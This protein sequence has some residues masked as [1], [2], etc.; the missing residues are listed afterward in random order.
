MTAAAY[1]PVRIPPGRPRASRS[2]VSPGLPA[3]GGL[4]GTALQLQQADLW[5]AGA[6]AA[7]A[8]VAL[9]AGAWAWRRRRVLPLVLAV[10]ALGFGLAGWRAADFA[11]RALPPALEGRDLLVEGRVASLPQPREFGLGLAFDI[12]AV[13][14]GAPAGAVPRRVQ[15]T[16]SRSPGAAEDSPGTSVVP[17]AGERWRILVRL[18]APHGPLN[19]RGFDAEL[20]WWERGIQALGSVRQGR[21]DPPPER[22][23]AA[24]PLSVERARQAVRDAILARASPADPGAWGVVAALVVGDGQ[25][26]TPADWDLYRL[27]GIAHLVSISGLHV[28]AFAWLASALAGALWRRSARLCEACPAPTAALWAGLALAGGYA[29]FSG[30]GVPAQRTVWMLAAAGWLRTCGYRWPWPVTGSVVACGVAAADPWALLQPGFWLSFVAVAVL[31]LGEAGTAPAAPAEEAA[32]PRPSAWGWR[33][34]ALGLL[35]EQ[36]RITLALAPLTLLLFGQWSLVG[37]LANLVAIPWMTGVVLPLA[38]AGVVCPPLWAGAAA[39]VGGL[40]PLLQALAA[41]PGGVWSVAAPPGW[42]AAGALAGGA[43]AVLPLPLAL[44]VPG[45]LLLLPVLLWQPPR[46]APGA[47]EVLAADIGQGTAVLVRTA[48]H[49]LLYD[50]GPRWAPDQ[51]AGQRVLV[52]LLRAL[53]VRLDRLVVSHQDTDHSGG[54]AAV[55][56]AHPRAD[57][58]ASLP[59]GHPLAALRAPQACLSGQRWRWDGVDFE[60]LHPSE[61][62]WAGDERP[63][64]TRPNALSCVLRVS[65]ADGARALLTGDIERPQE[66]ALVAAHGAAGL[67]ADLL[68]VPHHGSKT[69]SSPA[70]LDAV[71]P[72]LALVQAGY[73]NRYGHPAPRVRERHAQRGIPL[74]ETAACGAARWSSDTPGRLACERHLRRRAWHHRPERGLDIAILTGDTG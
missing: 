2:P 45:L 43:W 3:L 37:W 67:R 61:A 33:R 68:L 29:V 20:G 4:A 62:D 47:F 18:R 13:P 34:H 59:A 32:D 49:D 58:L 52:P 17:R 66:A 23:S 53:G 15:L 51:D 22:L 63:T 70:F 26:I 50:A 39:A 21:G 56:A 7:L 40:A 12:D 64:A 73:R 72:R 28:T 41:V 36:T 1:V 44:R 10:A 6:Y 69:S 11:G 38:L 35:R 24:S 48:G 25:A 16:W 8:L 27:T 57:L 60:V 19:P 30:W 14:S 55:L 71:R 31:F 42:V 9:L 54:A 5:L 46:P 74:V 65:A